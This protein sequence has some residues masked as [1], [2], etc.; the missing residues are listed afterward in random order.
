MVEW[1]LD[2]GGHCS[3]GHL[4]FRCAEPLLPDSSPVSRL[5]GFLPGSALRAARLF[6][7]AWG[8]GVRPWGVPEPPLWGG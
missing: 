2:R 8:P 6:V 4:L 3:Q 5:L 7:P 1:C